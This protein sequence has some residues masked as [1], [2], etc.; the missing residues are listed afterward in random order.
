MLANFTAL[1]ILAAIRAQSSST[2]DVTGPFYLGV[3]RLVVGLDVAASLL[4][5]VLFNVQVVHADD[6][7]VRPH[8]GVQ[9]DGYRRFRYNPRINDVLAT[10]PRGTVFD[11]RGLPLATS[12]E[13]LA[14][15]AR[16]NRR[17]RRRRR[18]LRDTSPRTVL[19]A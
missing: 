15:R 6:Y 18:R 8:A 7:V 3:E 19:P 9:A 10:I 2:F 17:S 1:G 11:R 16:D 4:V 14:S 12:D 13:A 5:A